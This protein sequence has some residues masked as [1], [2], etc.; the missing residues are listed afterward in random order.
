MKF[1]AVLVSLSL[2]IAAQ[3][4]AQA[5]EANTADFLK[6]SLS[7]VDAAPAATPPRSKITLSALRAETKSLK[8]ANTLKLRPFVAGRKL[9]R[10]RDLE[11][12]LLSQTPRMAAVAPA[13]LSGQ[14]SEYGTQPISAAQFDVP[15]VNRSI[16]TYDSATL[17]RAYAP[18][19]VPN[20]TP[21]V[22]G[23]VR[24][25]RQGRS[26][27]RQNVL[28]MQPVAGTSPSTD[29]LGKPEAG[30]RMLRQSGALL[31][32]APVT[33]PN[34]NDKM[35]DLGYP[36]ADEIGASS[37]VQGTDIIRP[38][39]QESAQSAAG[40]APFPLSLLPQD[41]LKSLISG[42]NRNRVSAPPAYFGSWHGP[43]VAHN[44]PPGGF[45]THM[46]SKGFSTPSASGTYGHFAPRPGHK[47]TSTHHALGQSAVQHSQAPAALR[48]ATYPAY[49]LQPPLAQ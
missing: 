26:R 13:P 25:N 7:P 39:Q 9:P 40:P 23:Q 1:S 43:Q 27:S 45:Q 47:A 6:T 22:P 44:L 28:P 19:T 21:T 30:Q 3:T 37:A 4:A 14:I 29:W 38:P 2:P 42:R 16:A 34:I 48:I 49:S 8:A 31:V 20:L 15:K 5:Q 24:V 46:R 10:Q 33:M 12:E 11:L 18:R 36:S 32:Q 35:S 17:A 41:Q